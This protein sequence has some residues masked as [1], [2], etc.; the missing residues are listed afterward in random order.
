MNGP[1]NLET[2]ANRKRLRELSAVAHVR[3]LSAELAKVEEDFARW[4]RGEI[5]P[6]ELSDRIHRFHDGAS[7]DI[8][9][10]YRDSRPYQSVARAVADRILDRTEI[11]SDILP[12]LETVIGFY[13]QPPGE[14][15]P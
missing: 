1:A 5:D 11:P 3:E 6:F 14:S 13:E 4:R 8:Y 12:A 10:A 15:R 9:V 7:R 2:K